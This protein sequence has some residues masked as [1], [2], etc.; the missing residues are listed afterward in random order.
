MNSEMNMNNDTTMLRSEL[1]ENFQKSVNVTASKYT[2]SFF[3]PRSW[4]TGNFMFLMAANSSQRSHRWAVKMTKVFWAYR[5]LSSWILLVSITVYASKTEN[6]LT[7]GNSAGTSLY[8]FTWIAEPTWQWI[9]GV[10][11]FDLKNFNSV[12]RDL[13]T[14]LEN[15]KMEAVLEL[16]SFG[17]TFDVNKMVQK[18]KQKTLCFCGGKLVELCVPSF[19][20]L[21][22]EVCRLRLK[23]NHLMFGCKTCRVY[24]CLNCYKTSEASAVAQLKAICRDK[25]NQKKWNELNV[26]SEPLLAECVLVRSENGNWQY[27]QPESQK[28]KNV[29]KPPFRHF[30][31]SVYDYSDFENDDGTMLPNDTQIELL[32]IE[33]GEYKNGRNSKTDTF[34]ERIRITITDTQLNKNT[35]WNS[36]KV[37]STVSNT[38]SDHELAELRITQNN[39]GVDW[40]PKPENSD[41][42][43]ISWSRLSVVN[44][45]GAY[46]Q[47]TDLDFEWSWRQLL[48]ESFKNP[49]IL[50]F[51]FGADIAVLAI[52]IRNGCELDSVFTGNAGFHVDI[53]MYIGSI[54][55]IVVLCGPLTLV[56][57]ENIKISGRCRIAFYGLSLCFI[58]AFFV[59]WTVFGFLLYFGIVSENENEM[60]LEDNQCCSAVLSWSIIKTWEFV[61]IPLSVPYGL[62]I[63]ACCCKYHQ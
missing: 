12:G 2:V 51:C 4:L 18:L 25:L 16:I 3:Q 7:Y 47:S 13:E 44:N 55:H 31:E 27:T 53:W 54:A 20:S 59:M 46:K 17:A 1:S 34:E 52:A 38:A 24:E 42:D 48:R 11:A 56:L 15:G 63:D 43:A 45:H 33:R 36:K 58:W 30:T 10:I 40:A 41:V 21:F 6:E 23:K 9:G 22:C 28:L 62:V 14:L 60:T 37:K 49:L 35:D 39:S 32:A 26:Q 50:C 57:I 29:Y 61:F 5:V 19:G 8:I